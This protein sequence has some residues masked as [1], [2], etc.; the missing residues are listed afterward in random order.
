MKK[1]IQVLDQETIEG[2]IKASLEDRKSGYTVDRVIFESVHDPIESVPKILCKVL[3]V[4]ERVMTDMEKVADL[5]RKMLDDIRGKKLNEEETIE[6]I[7][8]E[9][10]SYKQYERNREGD[11]NE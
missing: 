11:K 7:N 2:I 4:E 3:F 9:L 10:N 1:F 8:D 5:G 6:F